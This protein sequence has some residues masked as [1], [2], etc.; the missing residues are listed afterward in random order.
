M[1]STL[2]LL[3]AALALVGC[4]GSG[5][6]ADY[7]IIVTPVLPLNQPE[8]L[9]S[10]ER[11]ALWIDSGDGEPVELDLSSGESGT[12]DTFED[13]AALDGARLELRGWQG[14]TLMALGRSEPLSIST[15]SQ[16]VR[17]LV[18]AVGGFNQLE[19]VSDRVAFGAL[20]SAGNGRFYLF[21]GNDQGPYEQ[22]AWPDIWSIDLA[23]P[24]EGLAFSLLS[25]P[26]PPK[27]DGSSGRICHTATALTQ[28]GHE[29]VGRILVAGGAE[30]VT[31]QSGSSYSAD[32]TTASATAFLFDPE[33]ETVEVLS[34]AERLLDERCG[35]T[36]TELPSGKVVVAGGIKGASTG[37]LTGLEDAEIYD[38]VSGGFVPVEGSPEG[39]LVFHAAAA[40]S[41]GGVMLCGGLKRSV[42]N[43]AASDDCDLVTANGE[44]LPGPVLPEGLIHAAMAPLPDGK[45]LLTGGANPTDSYSLFEFPDQVSDRA[46]IYDGSSWTETDSMGSPRAM[47]EL[48]ALP[49][50]NVLVIG[51]VSQISSAVEP[52]STD[53]FWNMLWGSAYA[54]SCAELYDA[55]TGRFEVIGSCAEG[56][57]A[58]SGTVARPNVAVDRDFG[59]LVAGGLTAQS[60]KET[61]SRVVD[62]Y[63]IEP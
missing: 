54:V 12:I 20:A 29:L 3:S 26:M 14:T 10:M 7:Q 13:L 18:G 25:D 57:G 28:G 15:G 61:G 62:F 59:V 48:V 5:D 41:N 46:W 2:L 35:H 11:V 33:T 47:H 36:A 22:D 50:G 63:A 51:G 1:A 58:M 17:I 40:M 6:N 55:G 34:E 53:G 24:S 49:D 56:V 9:S 32:F 52:A 39:P 38:P 23:P 27:E 19:N 44:F 42:N 30:R 8:L 37:S 60:E 43:F 4:T 16:E 45:L 21:G 31:L